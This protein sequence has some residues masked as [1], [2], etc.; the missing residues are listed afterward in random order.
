M[1]GPG[2]L[3]AAILVTGFPTYT[4]GH[5]RLLKPP[6][7]MSGYLAGLP[8]PVNYNDHEMNCGG[9]KVQWDQSGGKCGICGEPW[10]G[11]KNYERPSGVMA[12]HQ[13]R[14]ATYLENAV[15]IIRLQITVSHRGWHEFRICNVARSGGV[16]ATQ[17]CLD[18]T[19]LADENMQTRFSKGT[20][21]TGFFDFHLVL[22]A[23]LTCDHC[24]I[25]WKWKCGN[26]WGCDKPSN[27]SAPACC[28]GCGERQEEF[29]GCSDV[30][31]NP[32][33]S[34]YTTTPKTVP[35]TTARQITTWRYTTTTRPTA[36]TTW[37]YPY[38]TTTRPTAR[39]T[40]R[41][42]Y[43][44]P[45]TTRR[46][47]TYPAYTMRP[48]WPF[49]PTTTRRP[50]GGYNYNPVYEH[51]KR[52]PNTIPSG[53]SIKFPG[54]GNS[55]TNNNRPSSRSLQE[56]FLSAILGRDSII[57]NKDGLSVPIPMVDNTSPVVVNDTDMSDYL[58]K[59]RF[60]A[61]CQYNCEFRGCYRYCPDTVIY[62]PAAGS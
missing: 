5:G 21:S 6:S 29:Y 58:R 40:W 14:T 12:Q 43:T 54:S 34:R 57:V 32:R 55:N 10:P 20:T 8:M 38:I 47:I 31:I 11:P 49:Y 15:I 53:N 62:C 45:T 30:T 17:A 61:A 27:N 23:G 18:R 37:R 4:H 60:C 36:R 7:R 51:F 26:D 19:L 1:A 22:P 48:Q 2:L 56:D 50:Y 52:Y 35:T 9:R 39:T 59:D 28:V 25:Q 13:I 3:L 24:V 46:P 16:E 33:N 44:T 41:Y 42:P